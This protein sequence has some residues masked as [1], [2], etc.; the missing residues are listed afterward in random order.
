M[1]LLKLPL[2]SIVIGDRFRK[3]YD[4]VEDLAESLET[5]GQI[6][7]P[8]I[9]PN[10]S[11]G[12]DLVAGGRRMTAFNLLG[13][14]EA[15]FCV[16]DTL[17]EDERR[18]LELEENLQREDMT[19]QEKVIAVAEIHRLKTKHSALA[20]E[21]WGYRQTGQ[22]L[23]L[24]L[25][26]VQY[27][28]RIAAEL[29]AV[30]DG[31]VAK[32]DSLNDALRIIDRR[33][34]N[35]LLAELARRTTLTLPVAVTNL[36]PSPT[37]VHIEG[38]E[39]DANTVKDFV[40]ELSSMVHNLKIEDALPKLGDACFDHIITDPP[41]GIDMDMLDQQ[42]PHGGM[43]SVD[44]VRE[45]HDVKYNEELFAF[46]LPH[47]FRVIKPGGFLCMWCDVMQW[48]RLYD[49]STS[50]G[51]KVQRWPIVWHKSHACMNQAAQYNFTK[52]HELVMVC[53]KQGAVLTKACATSVIVASNDADKQRFGHP[54]V[55]PFGVWEFLLAHTSIQ[56]QLI[57]EPFAGVGSGVLA[58]LRMGRR[59]F[60][61]ERNTEH[62][63][64]LVENV[65]QHYLSIN[66][67][68]IFV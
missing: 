56:G 30:P 29:K 16:A 5:L 65:K 3:R 32:A 67:N 44:A 19:W 31:D 50:T 27:S 60:A 8:L 20:G 37:T 45:E 59:V 15:L 13:W 2:S 25:G 18:E 53:R 41:Y 7:P 12:Y 54:F 63:N 10:E 64:R 6:H 55:K 49:L 17:T 1:Q 57:Y 47:F 35:E 51:F 34:E 28:V 46:M 43:V 62:F 4:K 42:N 58:A 24:A 48:Q 33:K 14:T 11:G 9:T 40:V 22:M 52:N 23:G 39:G 21:G 68:T 66:K 26:K 36:N 61:T 38:E